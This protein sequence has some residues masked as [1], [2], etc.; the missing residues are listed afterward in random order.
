MRTLA[1]R[2]ERDAV[3]FWLQPRAYEIED[4]AVYLAQ[5][6][7]KFYVLQ[8]ESTLLDFLDDEDLVGRND[9]LGHTLEFDSASAR[10]GYLRLRD[11][12]YRLVRTCRRAHTQRLPSRGG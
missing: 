7:G 6:V 9:Q 4:G 11:L 8:D 12:S 3:S 5:R 2:R 1:Y 10:D